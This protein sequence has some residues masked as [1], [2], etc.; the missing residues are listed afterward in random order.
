MASPKKVLS[1]AG[2][3]SGGGAGIQADLKTIAALGCYGLTAIT[4][5]TAQN[6]QGVTAI[7]APEPEFLRAQLDA[8]FEDIGADAVK[9]GMLHSPEIVA[10]VASAL[11]QYRP[12]FVV[13]DPVMVATSGDRLITPQT[14]EHIVAELFPLAT[15]VTPNLDELSWLVGTTVDSWTQFEESAKALHAMGAKNV[16]VKGGHM[17]S[18]NLM[19]ML[20]EFTARPK[21]ADAI[22]IT[23]IVKPRIHTQ[24]LHGTGCTL[25]SAIA[26]FLALGYPLKAAVKGAQD[27]VYQ[28]ISAAVAMRIGSGHGPVN[29]SFSPQSMH[30]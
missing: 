9:I 16:L 17:K 23:E 7:H 24:N 3:D 1:I 11:K 27:Y 6:T 26:C 20:V 4:A 18:P 12:G 13:L 2:S 10:V 22:A 21:A 15:I 28:A 29:H 30:L 14:Q 8:V 19:D 5:L 25:S